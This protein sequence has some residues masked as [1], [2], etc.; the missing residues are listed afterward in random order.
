MRL[1]PDTP[2]TATRADPAATSSVDPPA[3]PNDP[4]ATPTPTG[5]STGAGPATPTVWTIAPGDHLWHVAEATLTTG[6]G[7]RP[8]EQAVA[9]YWRRLLE[10]NA[11]R[12]VVAGEPDLVLPGQVFD[13]PPLPEPPT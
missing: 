13:L 6:W 8:D 2:G 9:A 4:A 10:H 7:H 11:D 5:P 3:S 1:V 12:L